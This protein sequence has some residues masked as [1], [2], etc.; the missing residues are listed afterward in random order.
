MQRRFDQVSQLA[1]VFLFDFDRDIYGRRITVTFLKKLRDERKFDDLE[2]LTAQMRKDT[3]EARASVEQH[4][5]LRE[6]A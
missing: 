2:A 5:G 1:H 4:A 3:A 6:A